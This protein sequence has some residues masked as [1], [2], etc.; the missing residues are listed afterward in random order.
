M[1]LNM[2]QAARIKQSYRAEMMN[3]RGISKALFGVD[4]GK[5]GAQTGWSPEQKT[6]YRGLLEWSHD[7]TEQSMPA[8]TYSYL[9][10]QQ[11]DPD[12]RGLLD[13]IDPRTR[14]LR[15]LP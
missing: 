9:Q 13:Q 5:Q 14:K 15:R 11:P 2:G 6:A 8:A 7:P 1:G 4:L 10:R 3:F 12:V